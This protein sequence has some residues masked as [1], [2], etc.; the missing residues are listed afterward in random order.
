MSVEFLRHELARLEGEVRFQGRPYPEGMRR[1]RVSSSARA[2][3]PAATDCGATT[4]RLLCRSRAPIPSPRRASCSSA[5]TSERT[6]NSSSGRPTSLHQP[7]AISGG[8]CGWRGSRATTGSIRTPTWGCAPTGRRWTTPSRRHATAKCAPS[9]WISSFGASSRGS[10]SRL[11][12]LRPT[13]AERP[14]VAGRRARCRPAR[15]PRGTPH[16]RR[17]GHSPLLRPISRKGAAAPA[18]G[19]GHPGPRLGLLPI[20]HNLAVIGSWI[21]VVREV[22]AYTVLRPNTPGSLTAGCRRTSEKG[23]FDGP[24]WATSAI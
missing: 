20:T 21:D 12:R 5:T 17:R 8:D 15:R 11:G 22:R 3:S 9:S 16:R 6:R 7:G 1:S 14:G 13:P 10:S 24:R 19:R 18:G 4:I 23:W 2:S